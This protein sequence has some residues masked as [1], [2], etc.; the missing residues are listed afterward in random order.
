MKRFLFV[1]AL[2]AGCDSDITDDTATWETGSQELKG[3]D[4]LDG[5]TLHYVRTPSRMPNLWIVRCKTG[6][7][8]AVWNERQGKHSVQRQTTTEN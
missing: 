2:V 6:T 7:A 4:G 3:I 5:C 1:V 8:T